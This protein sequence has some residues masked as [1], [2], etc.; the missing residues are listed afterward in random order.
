MIT[1]GYCSKSVPDH[2]K[3][4]YWEK[5]KAKLVR[6]CEEHTQATPD[7]SIDEEQLYYDA[8]GSCPKGRV[9]GLGSL[10]RKT[11]R[12]VDPGASTSQE[13][14]VRRSEFDAV[15]QRLARFEAFV[16]SHLGMRMDFG[17]KTSQAPPPPPPQEH[18]QQV[19]MDI[20][21]SLQQQHD[22]DDRDNL[23]WVD[24][25]HFGDKS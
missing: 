19:G 11:R 8:A 21:C 20:A 1:E 13:P 22:D 2:Q 18:H 9:Y 5:W 10:V 25:E 23:D 15:V 24:E 3:E 17:A 7:Q 6:R 4:I 16:Q 14:M 12:Y